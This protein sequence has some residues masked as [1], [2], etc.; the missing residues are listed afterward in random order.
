MTGIRI[1]STGMISR[2]VRRTVIGQFTRG[3]V[4]EYFIYT[5]GG[6]FNR[7]L[8]LFPTKKKRKQIQHK[9]GMAQKPFW[10]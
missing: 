6:H 9:R 7:I 2:T 3:H 4:R 1:E 10:T 8:R 5:L